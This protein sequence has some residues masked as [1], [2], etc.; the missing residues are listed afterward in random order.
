M[1]I[2]FCDKQTLREMLGQLAMAILQDD[3]DEARLIASN[4]EVKFSN[5]KPTAYLKSE[6]EAAIEWTQQMR[7]ALDEE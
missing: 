7:D 6:A 3:F 4:L 5:G 1:S 2:N